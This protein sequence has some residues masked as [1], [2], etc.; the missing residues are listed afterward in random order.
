MKDSNEKPNKHIRFDETSSEN[1]SSDGELEEEEVNRRLS[2]KFQKQTSALA[3]DASKQIR[4]TLI[5]D[6]SR[7]EKTFGF[8]LK[9]M[10]NVKACHYIDTIEMNSPA[11]RA[12]LERY[13][14]IVQVNGVNVQEFEINELIKQIQF[15]S[16][17]NEHKLNLV[18]VRNPDHATVEAGNANDEQPNLKR[19]K[20]LSL[21]L[22]CSAHFSED[23]LFFFSI[24]NS[25]F[26][27]I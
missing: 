3:S 19:C 5:K 26:L 17:L 10:P 1:G 21:I 22:E 15:E 7:Q 14:K 24:F 8:Q 2:F 23:C 12:R 13:D 11:H 9:G 4:V 16:S 25:R 20:L 18:V 6:K 27:R